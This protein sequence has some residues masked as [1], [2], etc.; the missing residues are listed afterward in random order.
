MML[1][2]IARQ[3]NNGLFWSSLPF[4]PAFNIILHAQRIMNLN[5]QNALYKHGMTP[6]FRMS[7]NPN[8]ARLKQKAIF[9]VN[10]VRLLF[11]HFLSAK[12]NKINY[13]FRVDK[14]P[15]KVGAIG[16]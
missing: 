1:S 7:G 4:H 8:W 2:P 6:V 3:P 14:V 15:G 12:T 5:N 11:L 10:G 9:E 16:S 13:L